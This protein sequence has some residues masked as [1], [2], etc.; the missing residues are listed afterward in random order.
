M[1]YNLNHP[2]RTANLAEVRAKI[3]AGFSTKQAK[4]DA[5]SGINIELRQLNDAA[6]I[7]GANWFDLPSYP[8]Q[9]S[10]KALALFDGLSSGM[11]DKAREIKAVCAELKAAEVVKVVKT[12]DTKVREVAPA[13]AAQEGLVYQDMNGETRGYCYC[14]GRVGFKLDAQGRLSRHGYQRPGFGYDVGGCSGTKHTPEAT[15]AIAI[16]SCRR[17][18]VRFEEALAGDMVSYTVT[19]LKQLKLRESSRHADR[20]DAR[21]AFVLGTGEQVGSYSNDVADTRYMME[22]EQKWNAEYLVQLEAVEAQ[23]VAKAGA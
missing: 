14:C 18:A 13:Q 1:L 6:K 21:I 15:L 17:L 3:A 19:R 10:K 11:G 7:K 16:T 12:D 23:R 20:F 4:K 22:R 2:S 8:H 9:I 5:D